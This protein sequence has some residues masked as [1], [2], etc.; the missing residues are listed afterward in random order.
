MTHSTNPTRTQIFQNILDFYQAQPG[1]KVEQIEK[2][3]E[4]LILMEA[5]YTNAISELDELLDETTI[6]D[7]FDVL[8]SYVSAVNEEFE[9]IFKESDSEFLS[10]SMIS[11]GEINEI[12]AIE[13]LE[14]LNGRENNTLEIE[15]EIQLLANKMFIP[16]FKE[17]LIN[18]VKMIVSRLH[19]IVVVRIEDL[20]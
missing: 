5:F 11:N 12:Q 14:K 18:L 13:I 2:I 10:F 16:E 4:Y 17:E 3:E 1:V 9:K 6:E 8:I 20:I 19:S 15:S 7:S